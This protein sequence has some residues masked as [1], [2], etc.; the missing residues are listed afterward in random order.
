MYPILKIKQDKRKINICKSYKLTKYMNKDI[1]NL[2]RACK[3]NNKDKLLKVNNKIH[4]EN[5]CKKVLHQPDIQTLLIIKFISKVIYNIV[6]SNESSGNIVKS[7]FDINLY[8]NSLN[9]I[10]V[11]SKNNN[12][13]DVLTSYISRIVSYTNISFTILIHSLILIDRFS[14]I[15]FLSLN[16]LNVFLIIFCSIYTSIKYN[17]DKIY[18]LCD[19]SYIGLIDAKTLINLESLF[20]KVIDYNIYCDNILYEDYLN[21]LQDICL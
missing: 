8:P 7:I 12:N 9:Q 4:T 6:K 1:Y 13:T 17:N 15:N 5:I 3:L 2:K 11:L 14:K 16:S 18:K 19:Y 21:S 10:I 20:I